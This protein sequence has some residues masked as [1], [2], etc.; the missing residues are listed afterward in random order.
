MN[1]DGNS[2]ISPGSL[3]RLEE[4][5][6]A[7]EESVAQGQQPD[8]GSLCKDCPEL[9]PEFLQLL[10]QLRKTAWLEK[11]V[12][13]EPLPQNSP[14]AGDVIV[15]GYVLESLLGSGGFGQVWKAT[16]P[17]GVQ[18]ALKCLWL[19]EQ[20]TRLEW[21]ALSQL[22]RCAILIFLAYLVTGSAKAG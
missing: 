7:W 2:P 6:D 8:A 12:A 17:G 1:Q 14:N 11:Q 13:N 5:L 21:K 22:K 19:G 4:L 20:R 3:D 9:L 18:V 16:G 10:A 15:P